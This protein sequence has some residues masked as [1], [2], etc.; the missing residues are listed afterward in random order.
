[1]NNL[2]LDDKGDVILTELATDEENIKQSVFLVLS[3]NKNEWFLDNSLGLDY[4]KLQG[5]GKDKESIKQAIREAI[6]QV[7]E[8]E[9]VF[10]DDFQFNREK[11]HLDIIGYFTVKGS[12]YDIGGVSI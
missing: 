8:V 9:N 6:S 1:M 7:E 4:T 10:V 3:I 12:K 11:R 2:K 5:K